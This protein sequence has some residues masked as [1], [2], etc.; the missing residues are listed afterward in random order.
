MQIQRIIQTL[1]T[2]HLV[3]DLPASFAHQ[4]V[5][6]LVMTI[7]EAEPKPAK[8]RRTPP[9]QLAGQVKELGDVMST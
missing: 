8:N 7:D 9:P 3:I 4:R 1:D 5:E 6:I 2:P